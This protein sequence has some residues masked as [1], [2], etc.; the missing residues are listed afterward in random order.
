MI[1][2]TSRIPTGTIDSLILDIY[3]QPQ[4]T[5]DLEEDEGITH[6]TG[7]ADQ[8]EIVIAW[9]SPLER[10][11]TLRFN[12]ISNA[13]SVTLESNNQQQSINDWQMIDGNILEVP[14]LPSGKQ[15]RLIIK[16][17]H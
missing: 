8:N 17:D 6:F 14:N 15:G 9:Q 7:S 5:Y 12:G 2:P 11:L 3:P 13:A 1:P 10:T 16:L 4:M